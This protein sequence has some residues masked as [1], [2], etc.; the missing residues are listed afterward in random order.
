MRT[1]VEWVQDH[2][3]HQHGRLMLITG[4]NS[5]IGLEAARLLAQRGAHVVL[6]CRNVERGEH[7][8]RRI[9]G[10]AP[11]AQ[12]ELLHLDVSDLA[13]VRRAVDVFRERH[14][15]LDVLVNNAGVMGAP[16]RTADGFELQ[17]GTNHLGHF[18]LTGLLLPALLAGE[19]PRVV[20]VSSNT[21]R[22]ATIL[23]DDPDNGISSNPWAAYGQSKL[24]NLLFT[25]ELQRRS[26]QAKLPLTA[27]AAHPGFATTGLFATGSALARR[28][29]RLAGAVVGQDAAHGALPTVAAAALAEARGGDY[30]GPSGRTQLRGLPGPVKVGSNAT[31]VAAAQQLWTLSEQLTGVAFGFPA[32]A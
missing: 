1:A 2:I 23:F 27:L 20:T 4:A 3:A 22:R 32:I 13:S 7:A 10:Y 6:A 25:F 16:G 26:A 17:F 24:A 18:A 15:H 19:R 21:H 28:A 5:G 14:D 8:L 12:L 11:D 31:D 30:W 9:A 29:T